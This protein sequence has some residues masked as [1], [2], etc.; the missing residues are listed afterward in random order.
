MIPCVNKPARRSQWIPEAA[1]EESIQCRHAAPLFCACSR[2]CTAHSLRYP[3]A[4][5]L[6]EVCTE[7]AG[8]SG[9]V[10]VF[11]ASCHLA[12]GRMK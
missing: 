6:L 11:V 2:R 4:Q 12:E 9:L 8:C 7:P 3:E 10:S 5:R 1:K